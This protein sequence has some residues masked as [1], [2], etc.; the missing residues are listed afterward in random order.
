[1]GLL[2]AVLP[3]AIGAGASLLGG[4]L[5]NKSQKKATQQNIAY[6]KEF[7]QKGIQWKVED[8]KQAGIHPLAALGANTTS[9]SPSSVGSNHMANALAK[10]GQD[11]SGAVSRTMN[12]KQRMLD[13]LAVKNA[14]VQLDGNVI[15]NQIKQ[16]QLLKMQGTNN[17]P[18]PMETGNFISG[19]GN[20]PPKGGVLPVPKEIVS[21][22]NGTTS[23]V[24][25]AT[26]WIK[27]R[28]GSY[29]I[30]PS[31]TAI[32]THENDMLGGLEWLIQN[33]LMPAF[34]K[35]QNPPHKAPKGKYWKRYWTGRYEL[36]NK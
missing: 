9:Y 4:A 14:Q 2:A 23:G 26:Q 36:K 15:D 5:G 7:A 24:S 30:A 28:D 27:N 13:T 29:S 35:K 19:Q 1:M 3:A 16:A 12:S 8:A 34:G 22:K 33:R 18:F 10:A 11:V 17:P 20:T 6:Q 31:K 21:G 25:S 32:E